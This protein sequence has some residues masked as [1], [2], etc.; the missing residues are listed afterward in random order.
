MKFS[1]PQKD[2]IYEMANRPAMAVDLGF[3]SKSK[4]CGLAWQVPG[5][6]LQIKRVDFGRCVEEV[7]RFLS[8]N[9]DSTL[10][11]EAPL[12]GLFHS[13][14]NPKGRTPFEISIIYGKPQSRYWY[15]GAG[16]AV[17]LGA[18][19]LFTRVSSLV[20]P[21]SNTVNLFEGFISFKTNRSD[22]AEDAVA[23]L[24]S[25][26]EPTTAEIYDIKPSAPG[27]YSVNMLAVSGLV[28]SHEE[29]P[30]VITATV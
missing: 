20:R 1:F 11:V 10:I 24:N 23:L 25:L 22:H 27:E 17:G 30:A 29:C 28:S 26:R 2:R 16:A 3:A 13:T 21:E 5:K 6:E 19:F 7:S 14:G 9:N 4:S 12:S 8:V 18:I 15:V